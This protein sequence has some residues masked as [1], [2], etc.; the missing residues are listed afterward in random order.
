[1]DK[2]TTLTLLQAFQNQ[3]NNLSDRI[4]TSQKIALQTAKFFSALF[5]NCNAT[6]STNRLPLEPATPITT[7]KSNG[8]VS[9]DKSNE[10]DKMARAPTKKTRSSTLEE[11]I[12]VKN[13]IEPTAVS[14]RSTRNGA[15]QSSG[16]PA[17]RRRKQVDYNEQSEE[18]EEHRRSQQQMLLQQLILHHQ[19]QQQQQQQNENE[20]NSV[21]SSVSSEIG[22]DGDRQ[23]GGRLSNG[24]VSN[25]LNKYPYDL[26]LIEVPDE[27]TEEIARRIKDYITTLKISQRNFAESILNMKQANFSTLLSQPMTWSTLSKTYKDRFLAMYAWLNDIDRMDKLNKSKPRHNT[28]YSMDILPVKMGMKLSN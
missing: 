24:S 14:T 23:N 12:R 2:S 10:E 13:E 21:H 16:S 22:S 20:E 27:S 19:H 1:M 18:E 8:N 5:D 7:N 4:Q 25:E 11:P 6:S 3:L 17:S 28:L 9:S 26:S 15:G